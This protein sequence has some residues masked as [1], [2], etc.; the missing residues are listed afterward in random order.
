[1]LCAFEPRRESVPARPIRFFRVLFGDGPEHPLSLLTSVL[2]DQRE[3]ACLV[4]GVQLVASGRSD[5]ACRTFLANAA[6]PESLGGLLY[7]LIF[8]PSSPTRP[9]P[10]M[11]HS[12]PRRPGGWP[13]ICISTTRQSMAAGSTCP[14]SS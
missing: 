4:L 6:G 14:R 13:T 9:P 8:Q 11:R 5:K 7:E 3:V 10:C 1:M 2:D 12:S